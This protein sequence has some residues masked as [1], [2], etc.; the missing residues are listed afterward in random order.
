MT[1]QISNT[2][3]IELACIYDMVPSR[4]FFSLLFLLSTKQLITPIEEQL[5]ADAHETLSWN[6]TS[7]LEEN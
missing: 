4:L 5:K 6:N 1:R 7:P 2:I 3:Q